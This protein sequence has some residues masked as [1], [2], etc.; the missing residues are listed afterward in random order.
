MTRLYLMYTPLDL[1]HVSARSHPLRLDLVHTQ[2]DL[3]SSFFSTFSCSGGSLPAA[4]HLQN[5]PTFLL[6]LVQEAAFQ[7]LSMY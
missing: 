3:I 4:G 2:L 7:L 6:D 1:I 5:F